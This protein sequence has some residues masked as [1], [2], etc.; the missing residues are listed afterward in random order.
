M[1]WSKNV[2]DVKKASQ[3]VLKVITPIEAQ[4]VHKAEVDSL[5]MKVG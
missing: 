2:F 1:S 3:A 5:Y 4:Y